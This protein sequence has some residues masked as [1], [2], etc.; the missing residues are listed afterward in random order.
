MSHHLFNI[1]NQEQWQSLLRN[2]TLL[3]CEN[4]GD[5]KSRMCIIENITE[6]NVKDKTITFKRDGHILKP[7]TIHYHDFIYLNEAHNSDEMVVNMNRT[8]AL[9]ELYGQL[10]ELF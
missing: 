6:L 3:V 8:S 5:N 4:I 9:K 2:L 1:R 10:F 7:L